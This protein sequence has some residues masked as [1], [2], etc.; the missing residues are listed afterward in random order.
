MLNA[1]HV[2]RQL[3]RR[4]V[5]QI[6]LLLVTIYRLSD[7]RNKLCSTIYYDARSLLLIKF[8]H[9]ECSSYSYHVDWSARVAAKVL[10]KYFPNVPVAGKP[11]TAYLAVT[12]NFVQLQLKCIPG[13]CIIPRCPSTYSTMWIIHQEAGPTRPFLKGDKDR[14]QYQLSVEA[15]FWNSSKTFIFPKQRNGCLVYVV[16]HSLESCKWIFV[17][18]D[19]LTL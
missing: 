15:L 16:I 7:G 6:F 12:A 11:F 10:T 17:L 19:T 9:I 3:C 8:I 18:E 14:T 1:S 2:S 4:I 13:Y 5:C